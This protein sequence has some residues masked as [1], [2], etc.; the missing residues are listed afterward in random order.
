MFVHREGWDRVGVAFTDR[1][2][3]V[4]AAP[5][6]T[7]NLGRSDA[8]N[9]ASV[10]E[11]LRRVRTALALPLV[12]TVRQEHT[13]DVVVVDDAFLD[14]WDDRATVGDALGGA[15]LRR[16]DAMVTVRAGVGLAVRV[17]DCLPV[18]VADPT[19][20][21]VAAIH[22]GRPGLAAQIIPRTLALMT[23]HGADPAASRAW[24]GPHVCGGCY[25]VP[26]ALRDEVA[27]LV[28]DVAATTSWGTPALDL[29][30]G[31]RAQLETAGVSVTTVGGCTRTDPDLYSYRRDGHDAGRLAGL[32]WL[33]P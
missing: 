22:G 17:A 24:I 4:S 21:V 6:D 3:G 8:D 28:P 26:A 16:A 25:E 2:G 18:M 20:R 27:A 33:S 29:A 31:A 23:R 14:G 15:R 9:P 30:A 5:Y 1:H 7:L 12:A 11:N 32:V 10:A 19:A 13:A